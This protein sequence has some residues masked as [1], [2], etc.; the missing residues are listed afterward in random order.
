MSRPPAH[1][2]LD[3]DTV[4]THLA[5][6]GVARERCDAIYRHSVPRTLELLARVGVRA[7]FFVIARDAEAEAPLWRTVAGAGHEVASHSL[8]HPLPFASLPPD[9]LARELSESRERLEQVIGA[10]VVGFRAPG[11]DVAPS[12]LEAVA[13]AG[14]RYDASILPSPALLAGSLLRFALSGGTARGLGL[15]R[16]ARVALARRAPHRRGRARSLVEFPVA[17]SPLVRLPFTHTLWYLAPAPLCRQTFRAL[18]RRR[19]PLC[20]QFHSADL[21]GLEEDGVDPRMARHPGMRLPLRRKLDLLETVLGEIAG[22]YRAIPYA[23]ALD[24]R[25]RPS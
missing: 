12:T 22:A 14:Y 1:V 25:A 6:Y 7:T 5:G 9:V 23:E 2:S 24:E 15:G 3:L 8:T 19:T 16:A 11:W 17:V 18:R 10:P 20:Y 13:R 21:L 4:D